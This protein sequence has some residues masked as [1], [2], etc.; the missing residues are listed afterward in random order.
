MEVTLI[1]GATGQIGSEL[2]VF[3]RERYSADSVIAS[4]PR[5]ES[6]KSDGPFEVVDC[7]DIQAIAK[8]VNKYHVKTIYHLAAILSAVAEREPQ[9]AWEV[10]VGGLY[11]V[12]EVARERNCRVFT[13]SSIGAFGPGT[14]LVDTPQVTVQR[15]TSMYGVSKVTGELLCNYYHNRFGLDTRGVRYPGI[16]SYKTP[17]GGGTTDYAIEIYAQALRKK[18]YTC[19]LSS[20]TFL[21]MMYMPDALKAAVDL[22][23]ADPAQLKHRNAYNV[24]AASVSPETLAAEIRKTI[25]DFTIDY[26]I[27]PIRQSIADSWPNKLDDS[28]A[29]EDWGWTPEY[30]L[31][32]MTQDML[33]NL[34][35]SIAAS[36]ISSGAGSS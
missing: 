35:A 26:Q 6:I 29:R 15:P 22:M 3:L 27:D 24:T 28:A 25:P 17:P 30:D 16:I 20:D 1:T 11:N 13:P 36:E 12:L 5:L 19:Y 2:T 9:R 8:A 31:A 32:T 7:T 14:P 4:G 23:E 34:S 18:S 33:K 21:D 10:N